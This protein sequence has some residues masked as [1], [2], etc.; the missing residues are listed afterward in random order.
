MTIYESSFPPVEV[1]DTALTPF[2]MA[3]F[4]Q[5]AD[6]PALIDAASGV[7]LSFAELR[8]AITRFAGGLIERGFKTGDVLAIM[9]LNSAEYA[10]VLHGTLLAGGT[11]TTINPLYTEEEVTA[12]LSN[13][14]ASVL[15]T[16]FLFAELTLAV[17]AKLGIET[18]I[19][20]GGQDSPAGAVAYEELLTAE[21]CAEQVAVDPASH[22]AILPYSSGT[23]GLPKGVMLSHRN[24]VTN[25][26]QCR[27]S[28]EEGH[29]A[30]I[31]VL[32]F[33]HIYGMQVL[34]NNSIAM[35]KT[36]VT[37]PRFDMEM[38]LQLIQEHQ[39]KTLYVVPPIVLALAML[40]MVDD[41]DTS[42]L[43]MV[44]SGAAPLGAELSEMAAK[45]LNIEVQQGYGMTELSPGTHLSQR[46]DTKPGSVGQLV[47]NAQCRIV[48]P[49]TGQD[50][51][52]NE[53]GEMWLRGDM[54]MLGYFNNPE[55]TAETIDADGWL[56][57]GDIFYRDDDGYYYVTD[58]LK[59]LIKYKGFQVP[60]AELEALLLSHPAVGDAGVVGKPDDE[61]GEVPV[62]FVMLKP[63]ASATADD[64]M[65]F[66]AEQVAGYKKL[67]A[68]EFVDAIPKSAS[69]KILR[70]LLREQL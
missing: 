15:V 28:L 25:I 49:A 2:V 17:A 3:D 58:R 37:M 38:F 27:G 1:P 5:F 47:P 19:T 51:E 7:T 41:Y 29:E 12:Q 45:R 60:P 33:F 10:V 24:L 14:E 57:T 16:Q 21:P 50:V 35:G 66:V 63:D 23:T 44:F 61:A 48:D 55:A 20:F 54:V 34:L 70:R 69:G 11:V 59:E 62:A 9:S 68:V 46:G 67:H 39:A 22:V 32:P 4:D 52:G 56:H 42:S 8:S 36:V 64:I 65:S 31:A 30:I 13:S 43:E 40:P 53:P 6:L 18:V 26:A